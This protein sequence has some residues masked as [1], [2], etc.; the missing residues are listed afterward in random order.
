[1]P[2]RFNQIFSLLI[3][4]DFLKCNVG[5]MSLF[6]LQTSE[7]WLV[8]CEMKSLKLIAKGISIVTN[9]Y[10]LKLPDKLSERDDEITVINSRRWKNHLF[11]IFRNFIPEFFIV[12]ASKTCILSLSPRITHPHDTM[13][14]SIMWNTDAG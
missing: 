3:R 12:F 14:G 8:F 9:I 10:W 2:W 5:L 7:R 4:K 6:Y 1:L 13:I 11:E